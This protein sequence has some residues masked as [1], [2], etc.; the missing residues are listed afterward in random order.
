MKKKTDPMRAALQRLVTKHGTQLAAS[1]A[2]GISAVYMS[3][4]LNGRRDGSV[5]VLAKLG[6]ERVIVAKRKTAA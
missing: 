4:L 1:Q 2:L 3:D 5:A 6:L